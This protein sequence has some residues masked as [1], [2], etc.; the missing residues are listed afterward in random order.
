MRPD[1]VESGNPRAPIAWPEADPVG[2]PPSWFRESL[3]R[4]EI[5]LEPG[6]EDLLCRFLGLMLAANRVANLTAIRN[7]DDAWRKHMLDALLVLPLVASVEPKEPGARPC[8]IDVGS[9]GGVP[10]VPLACV[11]PQVDFTL[12]EATGKKAA[13]LEHAAASL[14]LSNVTVRQERSERAAR[15]RGVNTGAGRSGGLRDAF[16]ASLCRALG[17]MRVAAELTLPFVRPQGVGVFVKGERAEEELREAEHALNSLAAGHLLNH[18]TETA[19][20]VVVRK[21]AAT[22][23]A[24]P[25]EDGMPKRSPL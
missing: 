13:F 7:L 10:A 2:E 3:E 17:A 1:R 15:D 14:G 23:R 8:I 6:E 16:D 24:Y 18:R 11:C 19:T 22:P 12:L 25:R 20:I 21:H 4:A 5:Q 9:G